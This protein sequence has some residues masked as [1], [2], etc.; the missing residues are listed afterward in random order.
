MVWKLGADQVEKN[1][2]DDKG[3][4]GKQSHERQ[5]LTQSPNLFETKV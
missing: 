5:Q 1:D 3:W 4:D 2:D